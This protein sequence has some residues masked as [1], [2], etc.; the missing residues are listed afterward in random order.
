MTQATPPSPCRDATRI[1]GELAGVLEHETALV[2]ALNIPDI[3]PLQAEKARLTQRFQKALK[4]LDDDA[5]PSAAARAEWMA[6]GRRLADAAIENERA[7]RIGRAATERLIAA[8]VSAVTE[9]R[10]PIAAYSQQR[11][12]PPA[13]QIAGVAVDRRL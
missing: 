13:P 11:R 6:A 4:A 7:L 12:M 1:A 3:A 10:P 2:R 5:S 9:S 8:V